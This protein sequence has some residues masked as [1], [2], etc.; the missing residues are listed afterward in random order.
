[1][2]FMTKANLQKKYE[3]EN[4]GKKHC[5]FGLS[6]L[7]SIN[8]LERFVGWHNAKRIGNPKPTNMHALWYSNYE[9]SFF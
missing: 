5:V 7:I 1:M 6:T 2:T 9:D 3:T 4:Q 8:K